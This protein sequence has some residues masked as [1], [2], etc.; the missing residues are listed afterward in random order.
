[1]VSSYGQ[2]DCMSFITRI[3]L[4]SGKLGVISLLQITFSNRVGKFDLDVTTFQMAV[5]FAWNQ[6]PHDKI[7]YE[8]LRLASELPDPELRK[9]V[10]VRNR[11]KDFHVIVILRLGLFSF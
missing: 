9:T 3:I 6:R 7:T 2:W 1:M 11:N 5:L 4:H 8:N 10:W